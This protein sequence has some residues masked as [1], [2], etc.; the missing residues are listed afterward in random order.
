MIIHILGREILFTQA[1]VAIRQGNENWPL[2][3]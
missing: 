2:Q 1:T 3:V